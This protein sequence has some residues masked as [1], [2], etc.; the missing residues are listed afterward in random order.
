MSSRA[1]L[2]ALPFPEILDLLDEL[3]EEGLDQDDALDAVV[4]ILDRMLAFGQWIPGPAGAAIET[5]DGP[6][7]RAALGLIW[8]F[9]ADP[10]RRADR[11]KRRAARRASRKAK[12]TSRRAGRSSE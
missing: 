9:A 6:V 12:R 11:R 5:I 1:M 7:L 8:S 2:R 10:E 3:I 4:E